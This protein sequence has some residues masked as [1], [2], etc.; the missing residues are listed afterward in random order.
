MRFISKVCDC[1]NSLQLC[2]RKSRG[3]DGGSWREKYR[4]DREA[5]H[6][7]RPQALEGC[8]CPI[9]AFTRLRFKY[10]LLTSTDSR[11]F[12]AAVSISRTPSSPRSADFGAGM[13]RSLR[14]NRSAAMCAR[15]VSVRP[16]G[17]HLS[18]IVLCPLFM[19][20]LDVG[21]NWASCSKS[22]RSKYLSEPFQ[23]RIK[24]LT[25]EAGELFR[26]QCVQLRRPSRGFPLYGR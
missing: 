17:R 24:T 5:A 16:A 14:T 20:K 15:A 2:G 26:N 23:N 6:I 4:R 1:K 18:T 11:F 13:K 10:D 25:V 9:T 12:P 3:R 8:A 21:T 19:D 7:D 22:M